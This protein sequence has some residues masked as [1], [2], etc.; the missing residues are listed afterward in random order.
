MTK[1]R[2]PKTEA[3]LTPKRIYKTPPPENSWDLQP[4]ETSKAFAAFRVYLELG[5]QRTIQVAFKQA[6]GIKSNEY[7]VDGTFLEWSRK[8]SWVKRALEFDAHMARVFDAKVAA[9]REK[10]ATKW[11]KRREKIREE[12]YKLSERLRTVANR[13][14]DMPLI[15]KI[16]EAGEDVTKIM[17]ANWKMSDAAKFAE[18]FS[19]LARMAAQMATNTEKREHS[20]PDGKPISVEHSLNLEGLEDH[21]LELLEQLVFKAS[22]PGGTV[23]GEGTPPTDS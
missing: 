9:E 16:E 10:E 2:K 21:E 4:G 19:K 22:N 17:P 14:L 18:V 12:E 8:F 6:R 11:E 5:P 13:M 3:R 15:E 23:S 20:G 7:V 1:P